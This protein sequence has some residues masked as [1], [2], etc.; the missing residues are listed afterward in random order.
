MKI[1]DVTK[2]K[3][4][5]PKGFEGNEARDIAEVPV[6]HSHIDVSP[7][8]RV[9]LLDSLDNLRR[10]LFHYELGY[11]K[12]VDF[13]VVDLR[14]VEYF[15]LDGKVRLSYTMTELKVAEPIER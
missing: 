2:L 13:H 8:D 6:F 3:E 5:F 7:E 14:D 9:N 1:N 15:N 4:P 11:N 10:I 12:S